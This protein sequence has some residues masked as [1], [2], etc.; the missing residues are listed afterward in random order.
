MDFQE[1]GSVI[2]KALSPS[3]GENTPHHERDILSGGTYALKSNVSGVFEQPFDTSVYTR[4]GL[5]KAGRRRPLKTYVCEEFCGTKYN[6]IPVVPWCRLM[7]QPS[8]W[9]A[10]TDRILRASVN[11]VSLHSVLMIAS[12]F[13]YALALFLLLE[14]L[15]NALS[16]RETLSGDS[17]IIV[18]IST[19]LAPV[20]I[21]AIFNIT[22]DSLDGAR[23]LVGD[24]KAVED[25]AYDVAREKKACVHKPGAMEVLGSIKESLTGVA[26]L[27]QLVHADVEIRATDQAIANGERCLVSSVLNGH[28][29]PLVALEHSLSRYI[30]ATDELAKVCSTY[31]QSQ[32]K[33]AS[34]KTR[35]DR[36]WAH[37]MLQQRTKAHNVAHAYRGVFV[38]RPVRFDVYLFL[39]IF[40]LCFMPIPMWQTTGIGMLFGFPTVRFLFNLI[41][42]HSVSQASLLDYL[43]G[44]PTRNLFYVADKSARDAI[45]LI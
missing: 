26:N 42:G 24:W 5:L 11:P 3:W 40:F 22:S 38:D 14:G 27:L 19:F 1:G 41:F 8:Q 17:S 28:N 21:R 35:V 39:D 43:S 16:L 10:V 36:G 34:T 23:R 6:V 44:I 30:Q 20:V 45:A 15:D 32:H 13:I 12:N 29:Q 31:N 18:L 9:I 33:V 4:E 7:A 25:A 37:H 2:S